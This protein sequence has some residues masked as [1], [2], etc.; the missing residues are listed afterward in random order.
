MANIATTS[1]WIDAVSAGAILGTEARCVHRLARE[2]FLTAIR[3]P[4]CRPRFRRDE[5]E[6]LAR[7]AIQPRTRG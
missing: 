5:V 6:S 2:G 3:L 7:A 4:A 1:A